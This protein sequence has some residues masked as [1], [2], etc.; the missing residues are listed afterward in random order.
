MQSRSPFASP[1]AS[2]CRPPQQRPSPACV[3]A[4]ADLKALNPLPKRQ[5]ETSPS[6]FN[7]LPQEPSAVLAQ[8]VAT[9]TFALVEATF[10]EPSVDFS[11]PL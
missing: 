11:S 10:Y 4:T 2:A 3:G 7:L 9:L 1:E 6:S 8:A 5:Q